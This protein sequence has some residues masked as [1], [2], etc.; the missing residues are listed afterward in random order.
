MRLFSCEEMRDLR[1]IIFIIILI[2]GSS[3][4]S[5]PNNTYQDAQNRITFIDLKNMFV[6]FWEELIIRI[7]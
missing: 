6:L 3:S 4:S 7:E 1:L 2:Y 5:S